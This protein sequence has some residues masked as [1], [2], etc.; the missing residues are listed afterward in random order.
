M[1]T[2][3][4]LGTDSTQC[5]PEE[6]RIHTLDVLLIHTSVMSDFDLADREELEISRESLK[7]VKS[8]RLIYNGLL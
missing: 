7:T 5:A 1:G 6:I 2:L 3:Q 4:R 8:E